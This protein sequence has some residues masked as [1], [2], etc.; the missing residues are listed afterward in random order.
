MYWEKKRKI[1]GRDEIAEWNLCA[2]VKMRWNFCHFSSVESHKIHTIRA[3][4]FYILISSM[5]HCILDELI[6]RTKKFFSLVFELSSRKPKS[7][8]AERKKVENSC[9]KIK[10]PERTEW[11]NRNRF[12]LNWFDLWDSVETHN[13]T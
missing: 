1:H 11:E 8:E 9:R 4:I 2:V 3:K 13:V 6:K 12:P 5:S 7:N 10:I